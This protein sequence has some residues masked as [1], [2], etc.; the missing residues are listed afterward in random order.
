MYTN[1]QEE[2]VLNEFEFT[3][4]V[5]AAV[6]ILRCSFRATL[7]RWYEHKEACIENN[8]VTLAF[9]IKTSVNTHLGNVSEHYRHPSG[10]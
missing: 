2:T 9:P 3:G 6:Q 4:S 10:K 1:E 7:Y 5:Q 8:Y